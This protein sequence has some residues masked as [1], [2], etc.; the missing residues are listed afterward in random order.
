MEGLDGGDGAGSMLESSR[1]RLL[2]FL[3][4]RVLLGMPGGGGGVVLRGACPGLAR[5][6]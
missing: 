4:P 6:I 5:G 2:D 1:R 3:V